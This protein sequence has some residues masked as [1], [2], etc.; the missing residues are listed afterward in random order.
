[1]NCKDKKTFE[2]EFSLGVFDAEIRALHRLGIAKAPSS[3][4]DRRFSIE[5]Q[6]TTDI[7][8]Q[9]TKPLAVIAPMCYFDDVDFLRHVERRWNAVPICYPIYSLSVTQYY[10]S[11][12]ERVA[13]FF[14]SRGFL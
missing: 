13:K 10:G 5:I 3:F 6:S 8:L 2:S 4:D 9:V 14:E 7:D 1:L 11:V 12:Y